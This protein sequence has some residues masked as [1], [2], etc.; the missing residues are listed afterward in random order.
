M[1][2]RR[3]SYDK[4][5]TEE[6]R[7]ALQELPSH[8]KAEVRRLN[9]EDIVE[10]LCREA[11]YLFRSKMESLTNEAGVE[12]IDGVHNL[13]LPVSAERFTDQ[14]LLAVRPKTEESW[15]EP[16]VPL[17]QSALVTNDQGLNYHAILRSELHSAD[18]VDMICPFIGVQGL[19]LIQDVLHQFGNN[20]RVLTTTYLGGTH[21]EA[22]RRLSRFGAQI[23][24]VYESPSQKTA[25]HAKAWIFHRN[26]DFGTA[27]IGSSNLSTRALVD[28]LEWNVRLG[29]RDAPQVIEELKTTFE[30]LWQDQRFEHFDSERDDERLRKELDRNRGGDTSEPTFFADLRPYPHQEEALDALRFARL[31]GRNR[32]LVVAATGTG[33]TLLAGFDYLNWARETGGVPKLLFVAHR[34]DILQQSLGAFRAVMRNGD[35][36]ELH[37]GQ[38]RAQGWK[39]V[40]ASVQSL[41]GK[42]LSEFSA[43]HFDYIIIDEFHHAEAPTYE[44]LIEFF[45]PKQL[46]GLTATPERSDGRWKIIEELWPPTYELRLW[47]A[48]GRQLLCPFHYFGIDDGTDLSKL[49]WSAGKYDGS[50]L[51]NLYRID[52][53]HRSAIIARELREK[54][55]TS[56]LKA[57]AFCVSKSHSDFMAEELLRYGFKAE[58]IHSGQDHGARGDKLRRFKEGQTEILCAVDLLS[59]GIDIPEINTVLFLRPTESATVFI[60]QL[61]RGL[62]N[63]YSKGALTVLDFV[64]QQNRKF[65][66]DLRF[67]AMT[68]LTRTALEKAVKT[69]FP[70]LPPGCDIKLDKVTQERI[71]ENLRSAVPS[72]LNQ[73]I[74]EVRRFIE[75]GE[76]ITVGRF[77]EETGMDPEDLYK[78]ARSLCYVREKAQAYLGELPQDHS[79]P[80][81]LIHVNDQLRV[82]QYKKAL[83]EHRC[84][85]D[86]TRMVSIPLTDTV[87]GE[88][89]S[90]STRQEFLQLLEYLESRAD[91]LPRL[92]DDLPFVFAGLYNRDEIVAPFRDQPNSMRQGTFWVQERELDVHLVTLRKSERHFS[93]TTRYHDYFEAID[94]L[95]WESQSTTSQDS[96]TGQRLVQGIGRHLFFVRE[97]KGDPYLCIGFAHPLTYESEKPIKIRWKLNHAVPDHL[98]IRLKQAAG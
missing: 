78:G 16:K 21:L 49:T 45:N 51:E 4:L 31:N 69:G 33:K 57:I 60:Q 65:R 63:H 40:F 64:G 34:Q 77:L 38:S 90:N 98:Y 61:G 36:G 35:F 56:N 5:I 54:T 44:R 84:E 37:V 25:L 14:L 2:L 48:L 11:T 53:D 86:F 62:R 12:L 29:S 17:S 75:R 8:L 83:L 93:P 81:R 55:D 3:G 27:L 73:L 95:H 20:L 10:Y 30:R 96:P 52:N 39:H 89:L 72:N 50:E 22:I 26:T 9:P 76:E 94:I 59:E 82:E 46:L 92:A 79:R 91:P 97:N 6:I 28:G 13:L 68:G 71:I 32:N 7:A 88:G 41:N 43:D 19:N 67:R 58:A 24:I 42:D 23:K 15:L 74:A 70:S 85:T 47:H 1:E 18:R 66:M 80:S 87:G